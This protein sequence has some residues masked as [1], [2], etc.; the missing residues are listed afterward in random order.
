MS[1]IASPADFTR[2]LIEEVLWW[3][4]VA[5]NPVTMQDIMS[6][7]R[8]SGVV[9]ARGD[10]MRRIR[11]VKKWSYP[12]IGRYFGGMD[13]SSVMHACRRSGSRVTIISI[14]ASRPDWTRDTLSIS[15]N[16]AKRRKLAARSIGGGCTRGEA[17]VLLSDKTT[18]NREAEA[19]GIT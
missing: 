11:E 10:C 1:G 3:H 17:N 5:G 9:Y 7:S 2:D 16:E 15:R 13:H 14:S 12:R 8:I 6:C 4:A 18:N 19:N